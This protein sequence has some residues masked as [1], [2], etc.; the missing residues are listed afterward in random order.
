VNRSG[1]RRRQAF[2]LVELLVV[3]AIIAVLAGLLLPAVQKARDAANRAACQNNL[4]QIGLGAQ[5]YHDARRAFP[6]NHRPPSAAANSVRERWFTHILPYIDQTPLASRYDES[7]NWDSSAGTN[8]AGTNVAVTSVRIPV[9]Q[10]PSAPDATRL[11]NNPAFSSPDGW[12]SNNPPIVAVTDYAGVY[13]VHPSFSAATGITPANPYG[14][15]TNNVAASGETAPV[16]ITDI[17]D[18]SSNTIL[19]A[20]SAGRP[21]LFQGS[22]GVRV[23]LDLAQHGVN[24]GGWARP[25]SEI[26]LIGFADKGG[27]IPGGP[28][29]VNYAN[30]VDTGGVYPL[31]VPAGYALGTDGSGQ[32]FGFHAAGANVAFADGSVH[33]IDRDISAA[34]I[35]AL[36]TRANGDIVGVVP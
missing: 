22:P 26:W 17:V 36:V 33:T 18:G 16:T 34:V 35:A 29:T 13:G 9:A 7:T 31:T 20:E 10:C 30:G 6:Q 32:I 25:A 8:P 5:N 23:G 11:D 24:G 12:G 1:T 15:I 14:V 3:I 2:T 4:R 27:T 28:Y 19:V 21:Y